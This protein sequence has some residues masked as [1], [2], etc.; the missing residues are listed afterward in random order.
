MISNLTSSSSPLVQHL[1][2]ICALQTNIDED[3]ECEGDLVC[4]FPNDDIRI[5]PGCK[6]RPSS[7]WE[8]CADPK[9]IEEH[10]KRFGVAITEVKSENLSSATDSTP[11]D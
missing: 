3:Y 1:L 6:G 5:V 10:A 2:H 9:D 4:F 7:G 8:Y 11:S